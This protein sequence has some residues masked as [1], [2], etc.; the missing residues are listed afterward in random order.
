MKLHGFFKFNRF[1]REGMQLGLELDWN[2]SPRVNIYTNECWIERHLRLNLWVVALGV[3]LETYRHPAGCLTGRDP[4]QIATGN[5]NPD[6][7]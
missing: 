3:I 7:K 5:P 6:S 4:Q 2:G 1:W